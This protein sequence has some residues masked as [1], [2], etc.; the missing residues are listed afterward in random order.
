MSGR[1]TLS[2]LD[3]GHAMVGPCGEGCRPSSGAGA[4][5]EC[6]FKGQSDDGVQYEYQIKIKIS[7]SMVAMIEDAIE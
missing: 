4:R 5:G 6:E 2:I 7:S 3:V 1:A